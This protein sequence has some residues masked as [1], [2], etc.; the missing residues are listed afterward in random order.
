M[1]ASRRQASRKTLG[2]LP[3]GGVC[4][5]NEPWLIGSGRC[6][7]AVNLMLIKSQ[8]GHGNWRKQWRTR[9]G[10]VRISSQPL[11][12]GRPVKAARLLKG[13][14][15]LASD[16]H[17]YRLDEQGAPMLLGAVDAAPRLQAFAGRMMVLDGSYLKA[18]EP[19]ADYA[20]GV[21]WDD[22]GFLWGDWGI[23]DTAGSW[24]L[25]SGGLT[26]AGFWAVA[27][28]WDPGSIPL[29]LIRAVLF[30]EGA[31]TGTVSLQVWAADGVTLLGSGSVEAEDLPSAGMVHDVALEPEAGQSLELAP[32]EA[33]YVSVEF[34]GGDGAN[35][36]H[37]Q[38]AST[39]GAGS[40]RT[41][42]G[43]QWQVDGD[44]DP[45]LSVGPGLPPRAAWGAVKG[46]R[47]EVGGGNWPQAEDAAK[48]YY[49]AL[50]NPYK[51]GARL[52]NG[53]DA[54]WIGVERGLGGFING[55]VKYFNDLYVSKSGP[56]S[57][58]RLTGKVPG[59]D[60]DMAMDEVFQELGALA[61]DTM[62]NVGN[63]ILFLADQV[64]GMEGVQGYG[65]VRQWPKSEE[66]SDLVNRHKSTG[67]FACYHAPHDQYWLQLPGLGFT[68]VLHVLL[69]DWS[70]Y[71]WEGFAPSCFVHQNGETHIGGDDGH[72]YRLDESAVGQDGGAE[73]SRCEVWGPM[74]DMGDGR[75]D[76]H[77]HGFG[78]LMTARMGATARLRFRL[79]YESVERAAL[80]REIFAP[81]DAGVTVKELSLPVED[82]IYPPTGQ[83]QALKH[84]DHQFVC[85]AIQAGVTD[86]DPGGEHV[87]LGPVTLDLALLGVS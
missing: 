33:R 52:Y 41:W 86:I 39:P 23:A 18:V 25:H 44:K 8:D 12:D 34:S 54:G 13:V 75:R 9:P 16:Q 30:A 72:F 37:L 15:Y 38:W 59:A 22:D 5:V 73:W 14:W 20:Y 10:T 21:V 58:H 1:R 61:G 45:L 36:V 47:L 29:R 63:N 87:Y 31:P 65:D 48:L 79:D 84:H 70:F 7:S 68:L 46:E 28:A 6:Q 57:I 85:K 60:G 3:A 51:W 64:L 4:T 24:A 17:L 77:V 56:A 32:G 11:P 80:V 19:E 82:W 76:K 71:Q 43:A 53:A 78:Y 49:C 81:I 35:A 2:C 27:P 50:N 69:G 55:L 67:A 66:I 40:A 74:Q 83:A 42:D 62:A 26:R